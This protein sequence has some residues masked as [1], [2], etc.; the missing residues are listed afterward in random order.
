M[1]NQACSSCVFRSINDGHLLAT[2]E[3]KMSLIKPFKHPNLLKKIGRMKHWPTT[4]LIGH[5]GIGANSPSLDEN[6]LLSLHAASIHGAKYVEFDVQVTRDLCPV[7]HHDWTV[8]ETGVPIFISQLSKNDFMSLC[9]RQGNGNT[10]H[11]WHGDVKQLKKIHSQ[12]ATLDEALLT[13]PPELGFNIEVKYPMPIEM[14]TS[15]LPTNMINC[16]SDINSYV[17][18]ILQS[19]FKNTGTSR[20]I[21]FSSFHPDICLALS[22]KQPEYPVFFLTTARRREIPDS[23]LLDERCKSLQAAIRFSRVC[24]LSG[25]V[26][27][28]SVLKLAPRL[29][30]V[31]RQHGLLLFTYGRPNNDPAWTQQQRNLGVDAVI[32]DNIAN[33]HKA[34]SYSN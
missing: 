2:I 27:E 9:K 20:P 12:F 23:L 10:P 26:C 28:S 13:L 16:W 11:E 21:I 31:V 7:L 4:V 29:I 19:V 15:H 33:I 8:K 30:S 34:F 1:N 22:R 3:G 32:V 24:N 5:R 18:C 14:F 17:D 6:S 25:I